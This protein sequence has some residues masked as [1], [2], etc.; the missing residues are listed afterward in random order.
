MLWCRDDGAV[1]QYRSCILH[2]SRVTGPL[3][4]LHGCSA[5]GKVENG[6]RHPTRLSRSACE[7]LKLVDNRDPLRKTRIRTRTAQDACSDVGL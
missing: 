7:P 5:R 6:C 4:S 2:P 3:I 1:G